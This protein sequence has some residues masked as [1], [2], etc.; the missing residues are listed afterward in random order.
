MSTVAY[1]LILSRL[2][3]RLHLKH[4]RSNSYTFWTSKNE[5]SLANWDVH[6][7]MTDWKDASFMNLKKC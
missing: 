3:L 1:I 7:S 4:V 2:Y 6:F 5:V